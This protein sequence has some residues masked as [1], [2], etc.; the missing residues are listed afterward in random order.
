MFTFYVNVPPTIYLS[1]GK[2]PCCNHE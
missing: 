2:P 1:V